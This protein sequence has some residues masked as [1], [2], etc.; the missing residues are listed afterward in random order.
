[1]F[2]LFEIIYNENIYK[3]IA[4]QNVSL[5]MGRKVWICKT[6][7]MRIGSL[8]VSQYKPHLFSL[9]TYN[10]WQLCILHSMFY[11]RATENIFC[12][13]EQ[14]PKVLWMHYNTHAEICTHTSVTAL[15]STMFSPRWPAACPGEKSVQKR[16]QRSPHKPCSQ[17][18]SGP[19]SPQSAQTPPGS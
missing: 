6:I 7:I 10:F 14:G 11:T 18:E 19:R 8:N 17:A 4:H 3:F 15:S 16:W 2:S 12:I 5:M 1:M 9:W 13:H